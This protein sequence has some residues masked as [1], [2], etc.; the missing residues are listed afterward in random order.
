MKTNQNNHISLSLIPKIN[1]PE[2]QSEEEK[3]AKC[4]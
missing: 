1:H 3:K 2:A 4:R